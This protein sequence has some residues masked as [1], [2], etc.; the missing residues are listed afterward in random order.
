VQAHPRRRGVRND[1]LE[2]R[3]PIRTRG[4]DR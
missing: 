3:V 1:V 4:V 2:S